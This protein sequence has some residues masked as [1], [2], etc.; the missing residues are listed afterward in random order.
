MLT[1]GT[2]VPA[3]REVNAWTC[4]RETMLRYITSSHL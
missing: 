1:A 4:Y 2:L 3:A